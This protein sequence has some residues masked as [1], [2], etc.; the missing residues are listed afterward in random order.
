MA[1]TARPRRAAKL[2]PITAVLMLLFIGF[3]AYALKTDIA[4]DIRAK[5]CDNRPAPASCTR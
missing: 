3:A 5:T 2:D 1:P 4:K